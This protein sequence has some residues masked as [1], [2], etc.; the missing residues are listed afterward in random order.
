[1]SPSDM[2]LLTF[3]QIADAYATLEEVSSNGA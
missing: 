2:E 3:E 1:V